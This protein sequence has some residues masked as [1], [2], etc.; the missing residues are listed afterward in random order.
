MLTVQVFYIVVHCVFFAFLLFHGLGQVK[1]NISFQPSPTSIDRIN[2][3]TTQSGTWLTKR[4]F[5]EANKAESNN[6]VVCLLN[7]SFFHDDD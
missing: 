3:L 7:L 2:H 1:V 6:D 5:T 4:A